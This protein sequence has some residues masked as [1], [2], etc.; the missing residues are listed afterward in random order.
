MVNFYSQNV[1][2]WP[3]QQVVRWHKF[4]A[5]ISF[6]LSYTAPHVV[7]FVI[8]VFRSLCGDDTP[9]VR[10]A[11]A[12]KLG[13]F[14]KVIE[15]DY[16][17]SDLIPLFTALAADEQASSVLVAWFCTPVYIFDS[18]CCL[19]MILLPSTLPCHW[20]LVALWYRLVQFV[21]FIMY[22]ISKCVSI[23]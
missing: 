12:S 22:D 17:K 8:R 23:Y 15:L 6:N 1:E 16:L 5:C 10:R 14:A 21:L 3:L 18:C 2:M 4:F 7:L 19:Q 9:M 11:A 20:R 13:E